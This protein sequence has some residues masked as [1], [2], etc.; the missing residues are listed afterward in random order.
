[1]ANAPNALMPMQVMAPDDPAND[2][3]ASAWDTNGKA[4]SDY[5]NWRKAQGLIPSA[6]TLTDAAQQY[7]NWVKSLDP[8]Q[9]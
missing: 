7:G 9:P 1:M 8:N 6:Q 5:W 4:L 2:L 3:T